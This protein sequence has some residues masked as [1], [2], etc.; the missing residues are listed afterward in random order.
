MDASQDPNLNAAHLRADASEFVPRNRANTENV[1]G[2]PTGSGAIRKTYEENRR[3]CHQPTSYDHNRNEY[4]R[5]DGRFYQNDRGNSRYGRKEPAPYENGQVNYDEEPRPPARDKNRA[6]FY[7]D[8]AERRPKPVEKKKQNFY[9]DQDGSKSQQS[10]KSR[11]N[12]YEDQSGGKQQANDKRRGNNDQRNRRRNEGRNGPNSEEFRSEIKNG[13]RNE[14]REEN[15]RSET[16]TNGRHEPSYEPRY[17]GRYSSRNNDN[18]SNE[19]RPPAPRRDNQ[20]PVR[21]NKKPAS[22][23]NRKKPE[24][25]PS[26]ISQR[27]RLTKDIEQHSLECM[28]CMLQIKDYQSIWSCSN[29]FAILHMNCIKTWISNSKTESGEWRCV[30]CQFLRLEVPKD[31]TCFCGKL[32]YPPNNPS[33]LAHS[34][35]EICGRT[36]NCPHPCSLKCHPGGHLKCQ[37][38]VEKSCGCGKQSKTFQCSLKENFECDEICGK[39]LSCGM[40]NCDGVCHQGDCKPCATEIEM[41]CHCGKESKTELCSQEN[42]LVTRYSCGKICDQTLSCENHQCKQICHPEVCAS[43]SLLPNRI[44]SC[45]CG[46]MKI[47]S[48]SRKTCADP[49]PLCKSQCSKVLNCGPLASPHICLKSCHLAECPPCS[50][51]TNVKCRCGRIEEKI[52]CKDL[53]STDVRCKK[54]CTKFKS[55]GRHKCNQFCCVAIEHPCTQQCGRSLE[56]KKHRCTAPCHIGNCNPC[57]RA[58]FDEMRCECGKVV[59]YPPIP[60]GTIIPECKNKCTRRHRCAHPVNHLCHSE[61]ECPPCMHL[62]TKSC[63]GKHETRKTIPCSQESF[64]CGLPCGKPIKCGLHKCIKSCHLGICEKPDDICVQPCTVKR[65]CGHNCNVACHSTNPCPEKTCKFMMEVT[66]PCGNVKEM[67]T[68]EQVEQDN[69]KIQRM[70]I[71]MQVQN[72]ETIDI[73]DLEVLK[74]TTKTLECNNE[75]ATLERNR[76]L[77]IAFK[78]ENPNLI[79]YPKF[80]PNYTDFIRQF[81]KKEPACANMIHEKLTELVK[82]SKESKQSSRSYSFPVMNRDKRHAVHDLAAMFGVETQAFDAE[83]NRNVV[84]TAHK[85]TVRIS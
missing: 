1:P 37:S 71:S 33:E 24:I 52:Q 38:S 69:C 58:S 57:Q 80:V 48:T 79:S 50:K 2:N 65:K 36:D 8:K 20:R 44:S 46:K 32:K 12:Y 64:S 17:D 85:A 11:S 19:R 14:M 63:Y 16:R 34:C 28:I 61:P 78:V 6:N 82:L 22:K 5:N 66:C 77:D 51:S 35:G 75:C 59:V 13:T 9:G 45:P 68:C 3:R 7:E 73:N 43:C 18:Q 62:T 54:K 40:H 74:K 49:I 55:C 31:Y 26:L 41:K 60:C 47:D 83:P 29:C 25:D 67:K 84:A 56:C 23:Q 4:K 15:L 42:A 30:A 10:Q 72:G 27:E 76:R 39:L 81:Y 53:T 21:D 70:K